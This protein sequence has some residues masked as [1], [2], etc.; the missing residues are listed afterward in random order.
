MSGRGPLPG[1]FVG[2]QE[3]LTRLRTKLDEIRAGE[4][5]LVL[6]EGA[7]GIGKTAILRRL[8]AQA[9]DVQLLWS[10]GAH[11]E[12]LV[13]FGVV[14]QLAHSIRTPLPTQLDGL[15]R[16][17]ARS[18]DPLAVGA[19]FVELLS[20]VQDGGPV[21]VVVDDAQ[22]ADRPSVLALLFAL[23]RLQS[24]RVLFLFAVR[25][26]ELHRLPEGLLRLATDER[27]AVLRLPGLDVAEV[28]DLAAAVIDER[29]SAPLAERLRDHTGGNPLHLEALLREL[30]LGR[31][32]HSARV[33]LP[34]PRSY[35]M[36]IVG[37]LAG[38]SPRR[39]GW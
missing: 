1:P 3:E 14:E 12:Q 7:A 27:G 13:P 8:L 29:L 21:V 30:P 32:E 28:Q 4:P 5:R 23:R 15:G 17:P 9:S 18:P 37:R 33:P 35:S 31:L 38:C 16:T 24:D 22:W 34:S 36:Q 6:L 19:A 2:R 25:E 26:N 20:G 11:E 39:S 10:S